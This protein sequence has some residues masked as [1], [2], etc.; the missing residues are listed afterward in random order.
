MNCGIQR[1]ISDTN[2]LCASA[3]GM[4][5][6]KENIRTNNTNGVTI[7]VSI[8]PLSSDNEI[9]DIYNSIIP[10]HKYL[11]PSHALSV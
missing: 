7:S 1:Y 6:I 8:F 9:S 5:G 4:G 3:D 2:I 11:G 10:E